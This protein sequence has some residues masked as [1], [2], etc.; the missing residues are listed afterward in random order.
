[1]WQPGKQ[2]AL[3]FET[4]TSFPVA[5]VDAKSLTPPHPLIFR[6]GACEDHRELTG[7][8]PALRAVEIRQP[9][10]MVTEM[11]PKFRSRW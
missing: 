7:V 4:P 11:R 10:S 3:Y 1:M 6:Q 5:T 2:R 8:S 9:S